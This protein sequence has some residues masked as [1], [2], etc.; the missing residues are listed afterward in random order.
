MPC[1][2]SAPKIIAVAPSPGIPK[3]KTG[4]NAPPTIA[5]LPASEAAIPRGSPLPKLDLSLAQRLA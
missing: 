3:V 4:I 5:L 1:T 2:I